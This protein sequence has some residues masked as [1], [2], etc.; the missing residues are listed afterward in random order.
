[1]DKSKSEDTGFLGTFFEREAVLGMAQ[2]ARI[3]SWIFAAVYGIF[4]LNSI[5]QLTTQFSQG[6]FFEKGSTVANIIGIVSGYFTQ[7][8]MGLLYFV[9]L[10][11]I[12]HLLLILLDVED[13]TRRAA[14]K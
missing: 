2:V 3:S 5:W 11:A 7:P 4:A 1:M 14:R 8:L 12:A 9:A 10:Q 6:V 13:N